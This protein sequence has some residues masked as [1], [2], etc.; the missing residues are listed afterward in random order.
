[1][2]SQDMATSANPVRTT[3]MLPLHG[4]AQQ[5]DVAVDVPTF[6]QLRTTTP[7]IVQLPQ[8]A[9]AQRL[10]L[11]ANGADFGLLLPKG[12]TP[13]V[14]RAAGE[15]DLA[16]LAE[17]TLLDITSIGEGLGVAV[18]LAPGESRLYSFTVPDERDIGVGVRDPTDSAH[19][20][21]LDAAGA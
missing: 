18:R 2:I 12:T 15:G 7:V 9:G 8:A 11:F 3:S 17:A 5:I 14:L 10:R 20:R 21:V 6:L 13:V 16:G 4:A 19:C 1:L